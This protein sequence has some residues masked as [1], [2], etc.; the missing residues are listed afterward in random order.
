MSARTTIAGVA[1]LTIV[2]AC[3]STASPVTIAPLETLAPI[4]QPGGSRPP[5]VVPLTPQTTV[6]V[7]RQTVE[8]FVAAVETSLE[9]PGPRA[10]PLADPRRVVDLGLQMCDALGNG[11][12]IEGVLERSTVALRHIDE[13]FDAPEVSGAVLTAAVSELCP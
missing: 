3:T 10:G 12:S 13:A 9:H 1:A 7:P 8:R 4:V 6:A 5:K 2:A 11:A